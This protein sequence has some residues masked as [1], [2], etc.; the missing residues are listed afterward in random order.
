MNDQTPIT[1]ILL[2]STIAL[3]FLSLV[4]ILI[5][6]WREARSS[7]SFSRAQLQLLVIVLICIVGAISY[8]LLVLGRLEQTSALFIG[9]PSLLS[10][11]A[12]LSPRAESLIGMISKGIT[13]ALLMSGILLGEGFI[14]ILMSAPLFYSVGILLGFF[15]ERY[16]K[17]SGRINSLILLPF[18]FMSMEGLSPMLS[19]N[20]AETV[21]VEKQVDSSPKEIFLRLAKTPKFSKPLPVYLKFGF[22]LPVKTEGQGLEVGDYRK[23]HFAGGEGQP[24]LLEMRVTTAAKQ[25]VVFEAVSD[26]S[27]IAHWLDW[28]RSIVEVEPL[29]EGQSLVRW[30]IEYDR[31]LDPAWY[32]GPWQRYGVGLAAEFLIDNLTT[33]QFR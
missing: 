16:R 30:T 5:K 6:R 23:I 25:R 17:K 19:F 15:I 33:A 31:Q 27:H 4:V 32:F 9:L 22:P 12:V 13:I 3:V 20:R 7:G 24:G 1:M 11:I 29:N 18:L 8:R 26:S 14:C 21:V 10:L 28:K 2:V